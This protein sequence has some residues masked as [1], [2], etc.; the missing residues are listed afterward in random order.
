[1][2]RIAYLT[3]GTAGMYCGACSRDLTV[4]RG[5]LAR[6]HDVYAVPLYTPLKIEGREPLPLT[7]VFLGGI[8]VY[9]QQQAPLF[10]QAPEAVRRLLDH[11]ALLNFASR[12]AV[13]NRAADLGP[14]TVSVLSGSE[15][16][17]KQELRRLLDFLRREPKPDLVM[18]TNSLLSAVAPEVKRKL[19]AAVVCGLQGEEDF[20]GQ[21]PEP[22]RS[23][24]QQLLRRHSAAVGLFVAPYTAHAEKMAAYLG[25]PPDR[26][27]VVPT[28]LE[29]D[30]Y[31]HQGPR[32]REPFTVGYL[33]VIT[34]GKGL[35][36]LVEAWVRLVR[37]QDRAVRLRIA[38]KVLD[39]A[40]WRALRARIRA[41]GLVAQKEYLGEVDLDTKRQFLRSLSVLCQPS[42]FAEA[43]GLVAMEAM[44]SGVPV[45]VPRRGVFP[46]MMELTGGGLMVEPE[47]SAALAE[48]LARLQDNPDE[49]DRLGRQ[50]AE[51]IAGHYAAEKVVEQTLAVFEEALRLARR[52]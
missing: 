31:R 12:F 15:G 35:D 18:I 50:G 32:V 37:Q 13:S 27:R 40:Y 16:R 21:M 39:K 42:R 41:A 36:L 49:A 14:M 51:G 43:R 20:L 48:A 7:D 6:G 23:Q 24:G 38:G 17:Q 19:G 47:N 8:N 1:M 4:I 3:A 30:R 25:V 52:R 28:G 34:P 2:M 45:V 9:L 11:P 46:E 44:A 22:Y 33:G 29:V 10:G 26:I 5:L